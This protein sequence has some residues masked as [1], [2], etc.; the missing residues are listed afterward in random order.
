MHRQLR[1]PAVAP[2]P[3][4]SFRA[5]DV[6][7]AAEGLCQRIVTL[8]RERSE[9]RENAHTWLERHFLRTADAAQRLGVSPQLL[10]TVASEGPT[11]LFDHD[12]RPVEVGLRAVR[13]LG[14]W[15]LRDDIDRILR[16]RRATD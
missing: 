14:Y 1:T 10:Q 2:E 6:F 11:T 7:A 15:F 9:A 5:P 12:G 3:D 8:D 16:A 4:A 13:H